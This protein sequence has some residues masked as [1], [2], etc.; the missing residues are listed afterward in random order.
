MPSFLPREWGEVGALRVSD[1]HTRPA[2]PR[3]LNRETQHWL[4]E[5]HRDSSID[6]AARQ[7]RTQNLKRF[8][9]AMFRNLRPARVS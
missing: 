8:K 4:R 2:Q 9:E 7:L 3:K 5:Q 6:L 1:V